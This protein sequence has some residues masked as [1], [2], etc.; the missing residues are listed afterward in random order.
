MTTTIRVSQHTRALVHDLAQTDGVTMQ[1]MIERAIEAY[2]RQRLLRETNAAYAVVRADAA[3][4][5]GLERERA[6][7]DVTLADGLDEV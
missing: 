6:E 4:E 7:W 1:E 3:A 2:R 5:A